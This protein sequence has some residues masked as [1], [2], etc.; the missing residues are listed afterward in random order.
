[1][2]SHHINKIILGENCL[3][4]HQ[5]YRTGIIN[6]P[7]GCFD[8]MKIHID[9]ITQIIKDD[10][11]GLLYRSNLSFLNYMYYEGV[12]LT[13][14]I[15]NKYSG[16]E[17]NLFS[18]PVCCLFHLD[19][20]EIN[21]I[22]TKEKVDSFQRKI[23]RTKKLFEDENETILFYYYRHHKKYDIKALEKKL[24]SFMEFVERKY[25]KPFKLSL[26]SYN[27]G[28]K[29]HMENKKISKN[30]IHSKFTSN[31][32]WTLP[33]DNWNGQ[34]DNDLFDEYAVSIKDF[35]IKTK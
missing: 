17:D 11:T 18:W 8:S 24:I 27:K 25:N 1:M 4:E 19:S 16:D 32:S 6:Q 35:I 34:C 9:S 22:I 30:I 3:L 31:I 20:L 5:L 29:N 26:L 13:K 10:F 12:V 2:K 21:K 7:H 33:D 15:N 28:S 14:W 23:N